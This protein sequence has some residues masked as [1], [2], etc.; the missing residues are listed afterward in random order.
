MDLVT[1]VAQQTRK[2]VM[3]IVMILDEK[4]SQ[5]HHSP[6]ARGQSSRKLN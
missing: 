3:G 6:K 5:A 2:S 4:N 1:E